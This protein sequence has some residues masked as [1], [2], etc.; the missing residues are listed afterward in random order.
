LTVTDDPEQ[1]FAL[2]TAEPGSSSE[3]AL[4]LLASRTDTPS[5]RT[6]ADG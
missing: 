2:H 6:V 1:T 3:E 5:T 4:R